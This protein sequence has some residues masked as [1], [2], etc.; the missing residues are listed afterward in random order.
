[1]F[2]DSSSSFGVTLLHNLQRDALITHTQ[3][4]HKPIVGCWNLADMPSG[5]EGGGNGIKSSLWR[6]NCSVEVRALP[7]QQSL[8]IAIGSITHTTNHTNIL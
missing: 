4:P 2:I 3:S 5:L 7:L 8:P 6:P 1:M